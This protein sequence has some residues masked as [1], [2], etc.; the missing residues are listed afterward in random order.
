MVI[1]KVFVHRPVSE[2]HFV[3]MQHSYCTA[4][5]K[6]LLNNNSPNSF[7]WL[8]LRIS[9][10]DWNV[11]I[12]WHELLFGFH[13]LQLSISISVEL[14]VSQAGIPRWLTEKVM[15]YSNNCSSEILSKTLIDKYAYTGFHFLDI[16]DRTFGNR[17]LPIYIIILKSFE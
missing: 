1:L 8:P 11:R 16:S 14:N 13:I 3:Y 12:P 4:N 2:N 10:T 9:L 17:T 15:N 5:M 7:E 6:T